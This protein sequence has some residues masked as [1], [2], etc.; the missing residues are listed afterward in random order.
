MSH[1]TLKRSNLK[2]Q[3]VLISQ[4]LEGREPRNCSAGRFWVRVFHGVAVKVLG[5]KAAFPRGCAHGDRA[6]GGLVPVEQLEHPY[7][8]AAGLPRVVSQEGEEETAMLSTAWS[9]E[10]HTVTSA[11]SVHSQP[12]PQAGPHS[13]GEKLSSTP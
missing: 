1:V 8:M 9:L 6:A 10:S 5:L 12:F 2:Q 13:R 7:S 4:G 3:T 11:F